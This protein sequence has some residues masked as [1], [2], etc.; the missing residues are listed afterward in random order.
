MEVEGKRDALESL[1]NASRGSA[2]A[3]IFEVKIT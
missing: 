1:G 3:V 2:R